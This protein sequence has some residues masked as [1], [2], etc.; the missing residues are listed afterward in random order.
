MSAA[1]IDPPD[2]EEDAIRFDDAE[3]RAMPVVSPNRIGDTGILPG[4]MRVNP[5]APSWEKRANAKTLAELKTCIDASHGLL[6]P[7]RLELDEDAFGAKIVANV[8]IPAYAQNLSHVKT[9]SIAAT[10]EPKL[11]PLALFAYVAAYVHVAAAKLAP[12]EPPT[13]PDVIARCTDGATNA[14]VAFFTHIATHG[15]NALAKTPRAGV[16]GHTFLVK[17][18]LHFARDEFGLEIHRAKIVVAHAA[19]HADAKFVRPLLDAVAKQVEGELAFWSGDSLRKIEAEIA[20]ERANAKAVAAQNKEREDARIAPASITKT[21]H[22]LGA[23][24]LACA[25]SVT[26]KYAMQ[27]SVM[28]NPTSAPTLESMPLRAGVQRLLPRSPSSAKSRACL[29]ARS[30]KSKPDRN[31]SSR[32]ASRRAISRSR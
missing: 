15:W 21:P 16:D 23:I 32:G 8:L 18:A 1:P 26:A 2:D 27:V 6:V 7:V 28:R 14:L 25:I 22:E 19:A 29:T 20:S 9:T 30:S 13:D 10:L 17:E 12:I 24:V 11:R 3:P 4:D 5:R 31:R